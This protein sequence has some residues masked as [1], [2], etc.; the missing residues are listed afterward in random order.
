MQISNPSFYFNLIVYLRLQRAQEE[1][2]RRNTN[3]YYDDST[4]LTGTEINGTY[5]NG[6]TNNSS[7]SS[8]SSYSRRGDQTS[9]IP[10]NPST[11]QHH[12]ATLNSYTPHANMLAAVNGSTQPHLAYFPANPVVKIKIQIM[13]LFIYLFFLIL[14]SFNI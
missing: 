6:T 10:N 2:T 9:Y 13:F 3:R 12:T 5:R 14:G 7:L 1:R 4:S 11:G 8:S